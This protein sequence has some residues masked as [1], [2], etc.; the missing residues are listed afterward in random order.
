MRPQPD[1]NFTIQFYEGILRN[2]PDFIEALAA[3]GELYTQKGL[4]EKGLAVDKKLAILRPEDPTIRY[5]LACSYSL[6]NRL[7]EALASLHKAIQLGYDDVGYLEQDNDLE[8][9]RRDRR[10]EDFLALLKKKK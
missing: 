1:L 2:Q 4:Y 10:F 3:L 6:M 5:N 9:L 8:N 7:D